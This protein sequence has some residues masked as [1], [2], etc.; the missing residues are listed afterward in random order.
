MENTAVIFS[1]KRHG[2]QKKALYRKKNSVEYVKI[3]KLHLA[4]T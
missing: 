3:N 1:N 2:L 4:H